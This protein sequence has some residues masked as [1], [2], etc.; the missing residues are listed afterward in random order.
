MNACVGLKQPKLFGILEYK[1]GARPPFVSSHAF[2]LEE[3]VLGD[4]VAYV[5]LEKLVNIV[6]GV[7][8]NSWLE[9]AKSM[10]QSMSL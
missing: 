9:T 1:R 4:S 6:Y 5:C 10:K 3:I 2:R 8:V 7:I